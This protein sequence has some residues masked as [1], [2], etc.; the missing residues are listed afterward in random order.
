MFSERQDVMALHKSISYGTC[1][2]AR[3][4]AK[5]S[6][7]RVDSAPNPTA[8]RPQSNRALACLR[9]TNGLAAAQGHDTLP[10]QVHRAQQP[11]AMMA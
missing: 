4:T 5:V 2:N 3:H 1:T 9:R 11:V 6:V 8:I 10:A 7:Q